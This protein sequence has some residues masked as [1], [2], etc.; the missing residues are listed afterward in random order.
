MQALLSD[1]FETAN[2]IPSRRPP[3]VQSTL[4]VDQICFWTI[5]KTNFF[6]AP[7]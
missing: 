2:S 5:K 7:K 6:L 4:E 3:C 1:T